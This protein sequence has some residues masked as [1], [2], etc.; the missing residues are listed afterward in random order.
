LLIDRRFQLKHTAMIMGVAAVV[1][2][3]L[4]MFLY[5]K[6][7]ENSR[8]LELEGFSDPVFQAQLAQSDVSLMATL[9]LSFI[10]FLVVLGIVSLLITHRMAGPIF[11]MQRYVRA[12]GDGV[13]PQVRGLRKHD[14]FVDLF[15]CMTDSFDAIER[16]TADEID[17]LQRAS[18]ALERGETS[19]MPQVV[20]ELERLIDRKRRMLGSRES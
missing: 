7:R 1:S 15:Q 20:A 18:D 16:R 12:L 17:V 13:I 10:A 3:V 8:M 2:V 5:E 11:V 14:E 9:L 19:R 6:I 4:G